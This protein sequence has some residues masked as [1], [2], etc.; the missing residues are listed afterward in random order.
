MPTTSTRPP[1]ERGVSATAIAAAMNTSTPRGT[2]TRKISRQPA[3]VTMMPPTTGPMIAPMGKML[4][5]RATARSRSRRNCSAT[6]PV[7]EGRKAP[8][9]RPCTSR[10]AMSCSMPAAN[11]QAS[12]AN[13]KITTALRKTCL[14]PNWSAS[15]PATGSATICP[16]A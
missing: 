2:L 3:S 1:G 10:D 14:R 16:T 11:P 12:E 6:R 5:N 15:R 7:A 4:V 13:V 8:P 9:A